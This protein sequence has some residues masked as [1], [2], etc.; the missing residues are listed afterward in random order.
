MSFSSNLYKRKRSNRLQPLSKLTEKL[1]SPGLRK[2]SKFLAKLIADWPEIAGEAASYCLPVDLQF[3]KNKRIYGTVVL[4][5]VSGRGP[6]VQMISQALI[7]QMNRRF[8]FAAV[9]RIRLRQDME[10][11]TRTKYHTPDHHS[12]HQQD[13]VALHKLEKVTSHIQN[14]NLRAALIRLGRNLK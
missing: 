9:G 14:P 11:C 13:T 7:T 8:G 12:G 3:Q 4:S 1:V 2:R 10:R 5:V 6:Q